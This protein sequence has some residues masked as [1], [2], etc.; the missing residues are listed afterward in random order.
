MFLDKLKIKFETRPKTAFYAGDYGK[1]GLD[2][3]FSLV[4]EPKTN[5]ASW[6]ETLKW[7]AGKGAEEQLLKI[8]KDSGIVPEDYDQKEH[9]RIDI[10]RNGIEIH[11]YIDALT[12][13]K[14]P[15]EI[16]T[17]NNK[18]G[19]DILKYKKQEPR[20]GYVGQLSIYL[21]AL[22]KNKGYLFV[23]SIDGLNYFLFECKRIR[24]RVFK[25]GNVVVDL[26]KEYARWAHIAECVK[27]KT[28]P[29][30]F[31]YRYKYPVNEIDWTKASKTVISKARSGKKVIGDYQ[32]SISDWKDKIVQMQG[33]TLGY[34]NEELKIINEK[35]KG[36]TT[37]EKK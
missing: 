2:L 35:T 19:F 29:D 5:P 28:P 3:Y 37:W 21:D 30:I 9:G 23:T 16:K 34:T 22:G 7:G 27:Q 25:C 13:N 6:N 33:D 8:L 10:Q 18:N 20:E 14:L 12:I 36:Y 4:G 24:D 26:D 11:G 32:V 15:I 1:P 31:E 17:I